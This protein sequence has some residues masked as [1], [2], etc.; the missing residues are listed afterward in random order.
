[1]HRLN[2]FTL[3]LPLLIIGLIGCRGSVP[4]KDSSGQDMIG[5]VA[6]TQ[7]VLRPD[8]ARGRLYTLNY[9]LPDA[10]M[11]LCTQVKIS[12][13]NRKVMIFTEVDSGRQYLYFYHKASGVPIEQ[14]AAETF[15]TSCNKADVKRLS[16]KDREGISKG[17][18][19][20]GMSKKGVLLAAGNPPAHVTPSTD[21]NQWTYWKNRWATMVV[22]FDDKGQVS[23][24][25]E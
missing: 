2:K 3:A 25:V 15:A 10:P 14:A 18:I 7:H 22:H 17:M 4:L 23:R 9:Q 5:K 11:P 19:L 13:I 16:Q 1:M 12:E 21:S 20:K 6:Y 24:I 8:R